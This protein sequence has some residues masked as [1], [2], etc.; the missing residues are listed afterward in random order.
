M[1]WGVVAVDIL[2]QPI[3]IDI[4]GM[5]GCNPRKSWTRLEVWEGAQWKGILQLH[6][7]WSF[8]LSPTDSNLYQCK[9]L[10]EKL[11]DISYKHDQFEQRTI[12]N[13]VNFIA[14]FQ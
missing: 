2:I 7:N 9:S 11:K 8:K 10:I 1:D 4:S 12:S 13:N 6:D 5:A 14:N 3:R